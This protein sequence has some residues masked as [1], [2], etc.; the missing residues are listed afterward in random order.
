MIIRPSNK[1]T[2]LVETN[3]RF[4]L[5]CSKGQINLYESLCHDVINS[6]IEEQA[7]CQV[8]RES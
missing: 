6:D 7:A 3:I 5:G 8:F 4:C 2:P 1:S